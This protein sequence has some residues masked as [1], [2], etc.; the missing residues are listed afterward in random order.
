MRFM[1]GCTKVLK[2]LSKTPRDNF[3]FPVWGIWIETVALDI[4][5]KALA[6]RRVLF[7]QEESAECRQKSGK[8]F[9]TTIG[10]A[11]S[12]LLGNTLRLP[13]LF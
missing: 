1:A 6:E 2:Q 3:S 10:F 4:T 11:Y 8:E 5:V 9:S 7:L 12:A 13:R